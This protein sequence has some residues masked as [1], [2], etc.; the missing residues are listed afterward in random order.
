MAPGDGA[1]RDGA[2]RDGTGRR[3]APG[4]GGPVLT[5]PATDGGA[6]LASLRRE[7]TAARTWV[8]VAA[9]PTSPRTLAQVTGDLTDAVAA[10]TRAGR[11]PE[12]RLLL[13]AAAAG[14]VHP[15]HRVTWTRLLETAAAVADAVTWPDGGAW[16][17]VPASAAGGPSHDLQAPSGGAV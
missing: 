2:R 3:R 17:T 9:G 15:A 1:R 6:S 11:G 5:P 10:A 12:A 8:T 4:P 7:L 13:V 14:P 16:G